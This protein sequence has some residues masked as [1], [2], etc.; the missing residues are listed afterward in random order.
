MQKR[1]ILDT[2]IGGDADD[3]FALLLA[4]NSP[5]I[6]L[7]LVVTSDE[8]MGHRAKFAKMLL[9]SLGSDTK[10]VS[11]SDL[12]SKKLC[13]VCDIVKDESNDLD[14][15]YLEAIADVVKRNDRTYY[16]C[17]SPQTNLSAFLDYAPELAGRLDIIIMGGTFNH[18]KEHNIAYDPRSALRI[19]NS[20]LRK[21]YVLKD[22]TKNKSLEVGRHHILLKLIESYDSPA[23]RLALD[24]MNTWFTKV[25]PSSYMHDPLTLSY[26]IDE[27][28]V[29][30]T[31]ESVVMDKNGRMRISDKGKFVELS[32]AADYDVFMSM[33]YARMPF[34]EKIKGR[35]ESF[36]LPHR[37]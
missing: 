5:E 4:L 20:N 31:S 16:V 25:H 21:L 9:K 18:E 22:I 27:D 29:K 28:L 7:E 3:T 23:A 32:K 11:G 14:F 26:L 30:F 35:A 24:S 8:H 19:F 2:D 10:V 37:A 13:L 1:V 12:G 34:R 17:I 15:N 36:G 6:K 33:L